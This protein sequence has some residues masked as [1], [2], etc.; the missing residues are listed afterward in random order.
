MDTQENLMKKLVEKA[1]A[2]PSFRESLI[3]NPSSALKETFDVEVPDDFKVVVHEDDIQTVHL[4]LPASSELTDTQ[5]QS[6]AGGGMGMECPS[7]FVSWGEK[8]PA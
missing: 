8:Q 3:D 1:E 2:D 6:A 5:L 4:V 7:G